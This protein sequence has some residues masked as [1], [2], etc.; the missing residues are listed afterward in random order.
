MRKKFGLALVAVGLSLT[1]LL[2]GAIPVCE[3][4]PDVKVVKIG[5]HVAL[6]GALASTYVYPTYGANDY[7]RWINGEIDID[8]ALVPKDILAIKKFFE[9]EAIK[10]KVVWEDTRGEIPRA[11]IAHRRFKESGVVGEINVT[12]TI[13]ETL[14][15]AY[16]REELPAISSCNMS[17]PMIT[18]P[19][20][21][22]FTLIRGAGPEVA[23]FIK[24][25]R[26]NWTEERPL[27]IGVIYWDYPSGLETRDGARE[28]APKLGVEYVGDECVPMMGTL[29]TST[30]WLRL[31][32]KKPDWVYV[33]VT[34]SSL[35]TVCKDAY[36]L[37]IQEKGIRLSS[38]AAGIDEI[39]LKPIGK[40]AAEGIYQMR[41]HPTCVET[42]VLG[43]RFSFELAKKCRGIKPEDVAG[44][45]R[46]G[47]L[48]ITVFS[49]A[50][51]LAIEKVSYENLTGRAVR[52][53]MVTI[54]DFDT[55]LFP[56][57]TTITEESPYLVPGGAEMLYQVREG[58]IW[59]VSREFLEPVYDYPELTK[60]R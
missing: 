49:E 25:A 27:R 53:A 42:D 26:D 7:A 55:G 21:W 41:P 13:S 34:G 1:L 9:K 36:R 11:I 59:P 5:H 8:E 6:T 46:A 50:I 23:S 2:T 47:M 31:V 38:Y 39:I 56:T 60:G 43:V 10:L 57:T 54:R 20:R 35:V 18:Y 14:A 33:T 29:D 32:G 24:W 44:H 45:Y 28:W 48:Y 51:R 17:Q 16:I 58:K 15:P 30:E 12:A 37:E 4:G 22:I 52:D 3:A 40:K 19:I